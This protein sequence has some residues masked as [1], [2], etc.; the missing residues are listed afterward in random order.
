MLR[1]CYNSDNSIAIQTKTQTGMFSLSMKQRG[2][3]QGIIHPRDALVNNSY[4]SFTDAQP[5][6][7]L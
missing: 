4:P 3:H 2:L 7:S 6:K 1:T 5:G